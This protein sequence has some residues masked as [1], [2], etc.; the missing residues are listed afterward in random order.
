MREAAER[1]R[2]GGRGRP[3]AT[4]LP[5]CPEWL[6]ARQKEI[7]HAIVDGLVGAYIPILPIDESMLALV[8]ITT[9]RWREAEERID[10]EGMIRTGARGKLSVHPAVRVSHGYA[11]RL[12]S[13]SKAFGM[14][15]AS[16]MRLGIRPPRKT[17]RESMLAIADLNR[18]AA[19]DRHAA[20]VREL[21]G[22]DE[23]Q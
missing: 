5:E 4:D 7:W 2:E 9:D 21:H 17:A 12:L 1:R 23:V 6:T 15:P 20:A 16:R 8:A 22:I 18:D 13:L 19:L 14:D 11:T 3:E 10:K